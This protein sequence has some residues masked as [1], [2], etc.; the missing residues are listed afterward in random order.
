MSKLSNKYI[1]GFIDAD[2]SINV[3]WKQGVYKPLLNLSASQATLQDEVLH[4]I[5]EEHGGRIRIKTIKDRE[6]TELI[7]SGAT[8]EKLLSK[9]KNELVIKRHYAYAVLSVIEKREPPAD[10]VAT[11]KWLKEQR[12]VKSLPIP[13]FP[14]RKWLAGY[15][16]GDG[17]IWTSYRKSGGHVQV[18]AGIA[19][20][21]YDTEGIETICKAFGGKITPHGKSNNNVQQWIV[22]LAPSKAIK[23]LEYFA[24]HLVVKRDQ[25]DFILACSRMGNFRDGKTI[26]ETLKNLKAHPH[27]LSEPGADV[28]AL[29]ANVKRIPSKLW[30]KTITAQ[31]TV[32]TS[33][34]A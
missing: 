32:G 14:P 21:W 3:Q 25:A 23:F 16:D 27:R 20:S 2:G 28:C 30:R 26:H 6:Y 33:T 15:F 11:K 4:L 9:I 10:L 7:L 17:S 22:S 31:A 13:N 12:R 19:C 24:K 5:K 18:S 1:A 29:V 8:A 34:S